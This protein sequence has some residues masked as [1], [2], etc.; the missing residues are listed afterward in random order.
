MK[1]GTRNLSSVDIDKMAKYPS[2]RANE[3]G[4]RPL[5]HMQYIKD[6]KP[7]IKPKEDKDEKSNGNS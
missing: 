7:N 5:Y 4:R 2:E 1:N 3:I 6:G